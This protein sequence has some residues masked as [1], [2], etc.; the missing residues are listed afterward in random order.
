MKPMTARAA[1]KSSLAAG[2]LLVAACG[3][4]DSS[5]G[6]AAMPASSIGLA[7]APSAAPQEQPPGTPPPSAGPTPPGA[8]GERGAQPKLEI[9][10]KAGAK[11]LVW[12]ETLLSSSQVPST[13][14]RIVQ[15]PDGGGFF[16]LSRDGAIYAYQQPLEAFPL[17]EPGSKEARDGSKYRGPGM[18]VKID[19]VAGRA[20]I[21]SIGMA[22]DPGFETNR[23]LYVWYA[24]KK[25]ENVALDRFRWQGAEA[26]IVASRRTVIRFS[27]RS[28]PRPYHMG[29]IVEFL[30]DGTLLIA[31]GDAEREELAQDRLDLNGKLLRIQ[32]RHA[33]EGGYDVPRDN[34][35]VN[36]ATWRPEIV[37]WGLRAPFRGFVHE[38]RHLIFGDVGSASE[39]IDV[40]RGVCA[41]YGWGRAHNTDGFN[42]PAGTV[43]PIFA[44]DAK[45]EYCAEDPDFAGETRLSVYVGLIYRSPHDRYAG[46]LTGKMLFGDLMRGWMRAGT[47]TADLQ[48]AEHVHIGHAP[49]YADMTIGRDGFIY[50]V[51]F[52]GPPR[53]W[54]MRPMPELAAK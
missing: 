1:F 25:D 54:R 30:A 21:G 40:Y 50:G 23:F 14:V 7:L 8:P 49:W 17:T 36:D 48:L 12:L 4:A 18:R 15:F 10:V 24:D 11:Q 9:A 19:D 42:A 26:E 43:P 27:R 52:R 2:L 37:S 45:E 3:D 41:D 31:T 53:L 16:L 13:A 46:L 32:P 20:D 29:G 33:P 34:P 51:S 28:P 22:L 6:G 35:H 39:E 38:G 5:P 44:Y 47:L